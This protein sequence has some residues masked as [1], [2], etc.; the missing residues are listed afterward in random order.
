MLEQSAIME[1]IGIRHPGRLI[2]K[3]EADPDIPQ[4]AE[5]KA[6]QLVQYITDLHDAAQNQIR[7]IFKEFT[8]KGIPQSTDERRALG[9]WFLK[10]VRT[11]TYPYI[12]VSST[13][14]G[15]VVRWRDDNFGPYDRILAER[16]Y[17]SEFAEPSIF[18]TYLTK[19][20][21]EL[22]RMGYV[23]EVGASLN[24]IPVL[25]AMDRSE[26]NLVLSKEHARYL[27]VVFPVPD[28]SQVED[29]VVD[30]RSQ[31]N[32][33]GLISP[34]S[35]RN[36]SSY[37]WSRFFDTLSRETLL[38][39]VSEMPG[40]KVFS[41]FRDSGLLPDTAFSRHNLPEN[42][43][44]LAKSELIQSAPLSLYTAAR[45]DFSLSR[46]A[47][48][49]HTKPEYFQKHVLFTNYSTYMRHFLALACSNIIQP[50][51]PSTGCKLVMSG[52][53]RDGLISGL[54]IDA[55]YIRTL[56]LD[57]NGKT[58]SA[59]GVKVLGKLKSEMTLDDYV[60]NAEIKTLLDKLIAKLSSCQMQTLHFINK[61]TLRPK[62]LIADKAELHMKELIDSGVLPSISIVNIGVGPSNAKNISDHI[63][64]L[65]PRSWMMVGH[66]GGL[67]RR[68]E[69]GHYVIAD[70][71]VCDD[72]LMSKV[73]PHDIPVKCSGRLID[74]MNAVDNL[75]S[76]LG[77]KITEST[78][79]YIELEK[80]RIQQMK[81]RARVGTVYTTA[82]RNWETDPSSIYQRR[83]FQGKIVGIDMETGTLAANAM[84]HQI[85]FGALLCV[86]DK[87]LHGSI[88]MRYFADEFYR[89]SKKKHLKFSINTILYLEADFEA[90]YYLKH[91]REL[92]PAGNPPFS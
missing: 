88:K 20:T 92:Q 30:G 4:D 71:V 38:D 51:K 73:I 31:L 47:H 77:D 80:S 26:L 54:E 39:E 91:S 19:Q 35:F 58:L 5:H 44:P 7:S 45:T 85:D 33:D 42:D 6:R 87:P 67:R 56:S 34:D 76:K 3:F 23:V 78:E 49:T 27:Q 12:F 17:Y 75:E 74:A 69:L 40:F 43:K 21:K 25:Y 46:L 11:C 15:K 18:K 83:S 65:R 84:R 86:S 61:T 59:N 2:V 29:S 16:P 14:I 72:G 36:F 13:S 53:E 89:Q 68:Q 57:D 60:E 9:E 55:N 81:K 82:D 8:E 1:K 79:E 41:Q 50:V 66:C 70:A 48:Y 32:P 10:K 37:F 90:R 62:S 28:V 63:A 52:Q 24:P 64:V 22:L